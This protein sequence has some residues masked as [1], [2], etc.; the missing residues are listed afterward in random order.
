VNAVVAAHAWRFTHFVPSRAK[1]PNPETLGIADRARILLTGV[2]VPR[3]TITR[4]PADLGLVARTDKRAGIATWTIDGAG[5]GTVLLFH[6]Y[7]GVKSDLLE[8][9][10]VFHDDGWSAVLVDFPGS[11]D[12]DGGATTL[13]WTEADVV[14]DE[15]RSHSGHGPLVIFAKSMGS[16]ATLRA[17][18]A[19]GVTAEAFV[20]ENPYDRLVTTVGHRFEAMGLP[21]RP[22]SDLLVL[23]GSVEMGF[24]AFSLNPVEYARHVAVPTL[25]LAGER[26]PRVHLD[27][28]HAIADALAGPHDLTVFPGAGHV[29]LF[30]ADPDRWRT[31]VRA[32]VDRW[33]PRPEGPE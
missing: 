1:T 25:L 19:L 7:G 30:R 26:D 23:W 28:I 3:P 24:D 20:L 5:R 27:E 17:A 15:I 18:G 32:F 6:G 13:G 21:P 11:G 2:V 12:S 8:E 9:A 29:G 31:A 4:Q 10:R 22:C 16:A 14:A 33:A